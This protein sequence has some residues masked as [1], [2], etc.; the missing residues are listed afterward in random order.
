MIKLVVFDFDG[1]FTDGLTCINKDGMPIKGY[2]VKDGMGIKLL[3]EKFQ[4]AVI[5]G[6]TE[7]AS[8]KAI[9]DHLGITHYVFNC[10]DKLARLKN[11]CEAFN[12]ELNEVAYMGDDINDIDVMKAV[13]LAGC[14]NDAHE[15]C[16]KYAHFISRFN[17]GKGA[18]REFV[19]FLLSGPDVDVLTETG[20]EMNHYLDKFKIL[21]PA[22]EHLA[23]TIE[24]L[25]GVLYLFGTG[26]SGNMAKHCCDILKSISIP[27]FY[28][29]TTDLLHGNIGSMKKGD[30]VILFSR[31]GNTSE[32]IGLI[33]YFKQRELLI[34]GVV[35]SETSDMHRLCD[36]VLSLPF[37]KELSGVIDKIPTNSCLSQLLFINLISSMLKTR[38]SLPEYRLNHPAGTIGNSL[39]R[40]KDVILTDFPKIVI[41]EGV[42]EITE[43]FLEMTKHSIGCCTFVN[44]ENELVGLLTDGDIRRFLLAEGL[45]S[46]LTM[47]NL[48]RNFYFETDLEKFLFECKAVHFIPILKH[49]E[50][51]G[52]VKQFD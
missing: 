39:K 20:I 43:V 16:K 28:M 40:I 12:L 44:R 2:N 3:Q 37:R 32:L 13:N 49:K 35:N 38:I 9:L 14:P 24:R 31:S 36:K 33:P 6:Y 41:N 46:N 8:Q 29:E 21:T 50:L 17:G 4:I 19:D 52:I 15:R 5:S 18:I 1:V 23:D 11:Y 22:I 45:Q 30:M 51:I 10:H 34:Y 25:E 48:N 7:N 26:K 42:I 27:A 47:E